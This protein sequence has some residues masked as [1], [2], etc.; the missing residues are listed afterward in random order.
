MIAENFL[1]PEI[2][3]KRLLYLNLSNNRLSNLACKQVLS[4]GLRLHTLDLS[5]NKITSVS[6]P[7]MNLSELVELNLSGNE[8][9]WFAFVELMK[10]SQFSK[11][12]SLD[13]SDN[14]IVHTDESMRLKDL[15]LT[16]LEILNLR[17]NRMMKNNGVVQLLANQ[18]LAKL[19]FLNISQTGINTQMQLIV[20][21]PNL[22]SIY[23]DRSM[24]YTVESTA[25]LFDSRKLLTKPI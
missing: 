22:I 15:K 2:Q 14:A 20:G 19:K 12:K 17:C 4:S 8:I 25:S 23:T 24:R 11:L 3:T 18:D 21:L 9:D 1:D 5:A 6:T 13:L 7:T 10:S 16:S